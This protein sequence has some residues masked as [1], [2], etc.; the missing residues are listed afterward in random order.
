[1]AVLRGYA[2]RVWFENIY[3]QDPGLDMME[4]ISPTQ[5]NACKAS[6]CQIVVSDRFIQPKQAPPVS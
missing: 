3:G 5:K 1:M 2:A 4:E 6:E